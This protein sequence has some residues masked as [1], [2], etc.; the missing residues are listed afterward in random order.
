LSENNS[1]PTVPHPCSPTIFLLDSAKE[2]DLTM[3]NRLLQFA[4][5]R[6]EIAQWHIE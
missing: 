2:D 1:P 4:L 5:F 6:Q 3:K